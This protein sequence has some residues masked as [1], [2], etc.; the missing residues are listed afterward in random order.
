MTPLRLEPATPRSRVKHSTTEPLHSHCDLSFN[1]YLATFFVLNML[2]GFY[3]CCISSGALQKLRLDFVMKANNMNPD[4]TAPKEA[5]KS[6]F[7]LFVI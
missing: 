3:V 2:S 1:L 5:V 4:L 6:G 7:I